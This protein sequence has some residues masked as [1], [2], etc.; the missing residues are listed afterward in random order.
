MET[1][2]TVKSFDEELDR[3]DDLILEMGGLV[4]TQLSQAAAALA[5]RDTDLAARIITGDQRVDELERAIDTQAIRVIALRQPVAEDLRR[6]VSSF[7]IGSN[8]YRIGDLVKNMAKR[9]NALAQVSV[10]ESAIGTIVRMS[11]QVQRMAK[12]ALD[13]YTNRDAAKAAS[14]RD[15]DKTVDETYNTLFRELLTYMMEDQRNITACM[16]LLFIGKNVERM[17]DYVTSVAEQVHYIITGDMLDDDRAKGDTTSYA[18]VE[19]SES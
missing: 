18:V 2:H 7:K 5:R 4:E 10:V 6:V 1:E 11:G 9:T 3:I 8:L 15:R 19:P 14:A 16:H 17:G 12:E 13:A